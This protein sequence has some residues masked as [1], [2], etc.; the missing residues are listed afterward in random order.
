MSEKILKIEYFDITKDREIRDHV[1]GTREVEI[2]ATF[3]CSY[4]D[5]TVYSIYKYS[6]T[7]DNGGGG[8]EITNSSDF[9]EEELF[10]IQEELD[11]DY[12]FHY[13][14]RNNP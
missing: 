5:K 4:N 8:H 6:A 7:V 12:E 10:D 11:S 1:A 9:T 14:R 2:E 13:I 3:E